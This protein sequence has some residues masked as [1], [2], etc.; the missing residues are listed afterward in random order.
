[1]RAP[2]D[3]MEVYAKVKLAG[4]FRPKVPRLSTPTTISLGIPATRPA[5]SGFSSSRALGPCAR[6]RI[7]WQPHL[8]MPAIEAGKKRKSSQ[9][10]RPVYEI[11][12]SPFLQLCL[13]LGG[14][15]HVSFPIHN[16]RRRLSVI[17]CGQQIGLQV[18][19]K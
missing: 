2:F 9:G 4:S 19:G 3:I 7:K 8:A 6:R 5:A 11:V 13:P 14:I 18:T 10:P 15:I 1:M 16:Q 17:L 12:S